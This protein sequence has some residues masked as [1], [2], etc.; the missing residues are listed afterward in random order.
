MP[1]QA[2]SQKILVVSS[3]VPGTTAQY[4]VD[5][6]LT[7]GH[8]VRVI[9][10]VAHPYAGGR[11]FGLFDPRQWTQKNRFIPDVC[12]FIEGG[13]RRL[14]PAERVSEAAK[15]VWYA[16]DS[17]IHLQ[18][19]QAVTKLFDLTFVAH[20]EYV[21]RL[22]VDTTYWLPV[23]AAPRV[24]TEPTARDL[25]I[26]YVGSMNRG[27]YESRAQLLDA[28]KQRYPNSYIGRAKPEDIPTIY[29]RAKIVFNWSL[30]N[31]VN[32]RYFEAMSAGAVLVT[33]K[34]YESGA[35][36]L[37]QPGVD[38]LEY[39]DEA[40][41]LQSIEQL[42][43]EPKLLDQIGRHGQKTVQEKH[44]YVQRAQELLQQ[45]GSLKTPVHPTPLECLSAYE[46]MDCPEGVALYA[47]RLLSE[48]YRRR[49]HS[50]LL[51]IFGLG[52]QWLSGLMVKAYQWR[53][54]IRDWRL[55]RKKKLQ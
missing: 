18:E 25:D 6:L 43:N 5:A 30:N 1:L 28:L 54:R 7:L 47:S 53:Y 35:E 3:M 33:N 2:Q 38:Y 46:K 45:L 55:S 8:D 27:M 40:N 20:Y 44:T 11:A 51:K 13:T 24:A 14:F 15:H 37:F 16:I 17:H 26:A 19:H 23:A 50:Q 52:M 21:A 48:I 4:L 49:D 12:F 29:Q 34:L 9:S 32:M 10:D 36:L 22:G 31:D 39:V 41:L 42:L